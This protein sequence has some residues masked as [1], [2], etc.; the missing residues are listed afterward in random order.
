MI[1]C[2]TLFSHQQN[3]KSLQIVTFYIRTINFFYNWLVLQANTYEKSMPSQT[4][5]AFQSFIFLSFYVFS[6]HWSSKCI[7]TCSHLNRTNTILNRIF[8]AQTVFHYSCIRGQYHYLKHRSCFRLFSSMQSL[9][10]KVWLFLVDILGCKTPISVLGQLSIYQY[11]P[12]A[13]PDRSAC[14]CVVGKGG[15]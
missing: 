12:T 4:V 5:A 11:I 9:I 14:V 1:I 6:T 8:S 10:I 2:L 15:I 13:K 3:M 7:F